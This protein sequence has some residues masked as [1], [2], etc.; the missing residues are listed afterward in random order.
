MKQSIKHWNKIINWGG[1]KWP[2]WTEWVNVD[3]CLKGGK[4]FAG[5]AVTRHSDPPRLDPLVSVLGDSE[6]EAPAVECQDVDIHGHVDARV[7]VHP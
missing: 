5:Q 1:Q 3:Q 6:A 7:H 4:C 2:R